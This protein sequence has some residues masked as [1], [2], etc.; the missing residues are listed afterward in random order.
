MAGGGQKEPVAPL[1]SIDKIKDDLKFLQERRERSR[2]RVRDDE[3]KMTPQEFNAVTDQI[4]KDS[5]TIEQL[6]GELFD[7]VCWQN[8]ERLSK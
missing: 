1:R 7:A 4:R 5:D 6:L 2:K 3:Q 8:P